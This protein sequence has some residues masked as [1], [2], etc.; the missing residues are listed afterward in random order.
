MKME[1]D[2]S[3]SDIQ[4]A[5]RDPGEKFV[6]L[7]SER[8]AT[9]FPIS[10]PFPSVIEQGASSNLAQLEKHL[11]AQACMPNAKARTAGEACCRPDS[12][13]PHPGGAR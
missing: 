10:S 5:N 12:A 6:L 1:T 2:Y 9:D 7:M 11:A 3:P 13:C 4:I 8:N